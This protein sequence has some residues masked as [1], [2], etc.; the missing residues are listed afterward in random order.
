MK[1]DL[2]RRQFLKIAG[3]GA[4]G[5]VIPACVS[6]SEL[7]GGK[8]LSER[9]NII[10]IMADDHA[11]HALSC[12]GSRI[13]KTPN[14]DRLAKEG[15]RFDNCFCTNSICAP[16]RAV[17]LT[18]KYS[19][20]NEKID[21][22]REK[23][24]D[25]SQQTFPKLLQKAGYQTAIIGKWHL[26]SRPTGFDYWSILPGQGKYHNPE[27][28][29]MGERKKYTGYV[30]D[31]IT[32][33]CLNWLRQRDTGKP[34][35]LMYHHKAPH[36]NWQPDEKHAKMYDNVDIPVPE[37][38]DDD[39][40][41][42]SDAAREQEMT[43]SDHLSVPGDT[44]IKPPEGLTG[45]A[46]KK[47]KY[48]RYIKDY[49][50]CVAS[51]DD[52]VGRLLRY[53]DESGLAESTVVVYTS[54]QGFFLGDHGWF[55][56]RFMYEE[57]LRMPLLVRYPRE[58]RAGTVNRDIVLNLD[59][60]PTFLGFAGV[61]VPADMQGGSFRSLLGGKT[62][63]DWRTSMYYHYYEYPAAHAVKRHYGI[64]TKRYKLIHFYYDIDAW[65]LYDLKKDP[66]ELNNLY[67]KTGYENV[68][69]ELKAEL[70]RLRK[71]YGDSDELTQKFLQEYLKNR[72]KRT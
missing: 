9:P 36:R 41:T 16:S 18:G 23:P 67:G 14:L 71:Q 15:M 4:A 56:K 29:E 12:Y 42:R 1:A 28:I 51:V 61:A 63:K 8:T 66:H 5:L 30:T 59:F 35:F 32:D 44:K 37:T 49:L 33:F 47:W 31:L 20:I 55:D 52:N 24:F 26:G 48:Q 27:F 39:Y 10:F 19:H 7:F 50:R 22:S 65:E 40:K 62:P 60:A 3:L 68:T 58:I 25:G 17:I 21:N 6:E 38:F 69:Q 11:S 70:E 53:L 43:I 72:A 2:N 46:L 57:S 45:P 64:R 13:N 34:F 54:D